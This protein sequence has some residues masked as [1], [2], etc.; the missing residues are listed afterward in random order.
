L[1]HCA[2]SQLDRDGPIIPP[3]ISRQLDRFERRTFRRYLFRGIRELRTFVVS[4][5]H[6]AAQQAVG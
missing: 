4:M 3:D 6:K 5:T 1:I 2:V